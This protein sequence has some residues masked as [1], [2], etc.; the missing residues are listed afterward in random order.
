MPAIFSIVFL[1][2]LKIAK[3]EAK[4]K[5]ELTMLQT[6]SVKKDDFTWVEKGKEI[7]IGDHMFDIKSMEEKDNLFS[8]TG[9]YDEQEDQLHQRLKD[10]NNNENNGEQNKLFSFF[11]NSFYFLP[12]YVQ[13]QDDFAGSKTSYI[14]YF[15]LLLPSPYSETLSPPPNLFDIFQL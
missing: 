11:F 15:S 7:R 9:I 6:I 12:F 3:H 13:S 8:F 14:N 5:L 1:V 2:Q 4:E 10:F